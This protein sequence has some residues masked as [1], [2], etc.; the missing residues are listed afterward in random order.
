MGVV[1]FSVTVKGAVNVPLGTE[2]STLPVGMFVEPV[3]APPPLLS[4][5]VPELPPLVPAMPDAEPPLVDNVAE[6]FIDCF[7]HAAPN[8]TEPRTTSKRADALARLAS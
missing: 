8:E 4:G 5:I 7:A 1:V 2:N 6:S 3:P